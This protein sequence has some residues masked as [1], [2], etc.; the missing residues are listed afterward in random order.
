MLRHKMVAAAVFAFMLMAVLCGCRSDIYHQNRAIERARTFLLEE[1]KE[2]NWRQ[3]EFVRYAD[4]V[5]LHSHVLGTVHFGN[6]DLLG[7]ESR[8]ICV[9]WQL[10]EQKGVYMVYGVSNGRMEYWKPEKL[11]R[12][13]FSK[14]PTPLAAS[15]ETAVK[16]AISNLS[17]ELT[18]K[19]LN[20][21]RFSAPSLHMTNFDVTL[22]LPED[23]AEQAAFAEA[24]GRKM[25][26]TLVW[27]INGEKTVFFCGNGMPDMTQWTIERAGIITQKEL[28]SRTL[29]TVLTSEQYNENLPKL[30]NR[31]SVGCNCQDSE[32]CRRE[33]VCKNAERKMRY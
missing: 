11:I 32:A 7:G 1:A 19:E 15:A 14:V 33:G 21:I 25:Q 6:P 3:Q 27:N 18:E 12:K 9:T 13:E 26:L 30:A 2:L 31:S 28:E 22:K 5:I 4:P 29:R 16:Y 23:P 10:P 17:G 8:Q 24:A 20:F